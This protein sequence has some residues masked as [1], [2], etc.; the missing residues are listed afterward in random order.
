[1]VALAAQGLDLIKPTIHASDFSCR[2]T[3]RLIGGH[4][5]GVSDMM[6]EATRSEAVVV[7]SSETDDSRSGLIGPGE[8]MV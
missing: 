7:V 6:I 1:L 8:I 2:F 3:P 4:A 5:G